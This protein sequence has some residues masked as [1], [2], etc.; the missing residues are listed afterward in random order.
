MSHYK[1]NLRDVEFNLFEVL[2]LGGML[3]TEPF[4]EFDEDTTRDI[5][6]EVER[7]ASN[8]FAAGFAQ[9]DR[10]PPKLVDGKVTLPEGI[11]NSLD[12]FY[13]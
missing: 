11:K 13:D 7:V 4:P 3:G 5:L 6:R 9:A 12:A 10:N 1:S 2:G 8:E